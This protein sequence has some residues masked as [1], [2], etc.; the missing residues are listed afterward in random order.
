MK[1]AL[2]IILILLITLALDWAALDDITTGHEPDFAAEYIVLVASIP[3][4]I[5]SLSKLIPPHLSPTSKT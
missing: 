3:I 2:L 1:K 5:F 4:L